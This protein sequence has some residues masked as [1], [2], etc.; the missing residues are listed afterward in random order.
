[1]LFHWVI[2]ILAVIIVEIILYSVLHE[3]TD[4]TD[5]QITLVQYI[6][7][8][9]IGSLFLTIPKL[10]LPLDAKWSAFLQFSGVLL[11]AVGVGGIIF[12]FYSIL[13][14]MLYANTRVTLI[15][16]EP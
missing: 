1:M 11:I 14:A 5:S 7:G 8:A 10:G 12:V 9:G 15:D 2:T 13:S 3:K 4:W 6:C 16:P